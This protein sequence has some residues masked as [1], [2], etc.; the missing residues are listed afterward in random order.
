MSP[1]HRLPRARV[2]QRE[3]YLLELCRRRDVLHLGCVDWPYTRQRLENRSLLHLRLSEVCGRLVGVD[4]DG[5]SVAILREH[6]IDDVF[7]RD[8]A[9]IGELCAELGWTPE[10]ILAGEI[11][12]HSDT[13][14][15]L[16]Q[17][18]RQAMGDG[19]LLVIT[20]PNAYSAKALIH[21]LLGHEKVHPDHVAYHSYCTLRELLR[22]CDLEP[23]EVACYRTVNPDWPERFAN[24]LLRPLLFLRPYLA[25][26]LIVTCS[27]TAGNAGPAPRTT[28]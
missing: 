5:E 26:G 4:N 14:K 18:V 2:V 3:R 13:P 25:D 11:L 28:P 24:L 1:H 8:G 20:V 21:M 10:V 17:G 16:L 15:Q 22:R 7:C 6:G 12:E 19:V 27:A 23:G 9:D